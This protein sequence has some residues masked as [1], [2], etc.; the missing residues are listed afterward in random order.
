[1]RKKVI[2]GL[3]CFI[4]KNNKGYWTVTESRTGMAVTGATNKK[5]AIQKAKEGIHKQGE[6]IESIIQSGID[7]YGLSPLYKEY[8]VI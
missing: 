2:D 8:Q 1:M 4:H 6:R 7:R 3:T 5:E